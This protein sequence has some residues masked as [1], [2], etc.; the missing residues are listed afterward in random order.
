MAETRS[1]D[2]LALVYNYLPKE[3]LDVLLDELL[4]GSG[5]EK[6]AWARVRNDSRYEMWYPGNLTEDGRPR[7][8]ESRYAFTVEQYRD[9]YR[10]YKLNVDILNPRI[11][12]LVRGEVSPTEFGDRVQVTWERVVSASESTQQYYTTM[13]GVPLT[14]EA[15]LAGALDPTLG[16]QILKDEISVAEVG[17]QALGSGFDM[18]ISRVEELVSEGMDVERADKLFGDAE[19]LVPILN[20]LAQ[21]HNDPDDDYDVEEFL[22]ADFFRDP[23]ENL[24]MRRMLSQERS[25][26]KNNLTARRS[27]TGGLTGLLAE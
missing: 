19:R 12:D 6:V 22:Q 14:V 21:R 10:A 24:R 15:M 25:L 16:T 4:D 17:G 2:E 26:F 18:S 27:E 13:K 8:D 7:Y 3:A 11:G 9:V 1:R 5:D 20:V 23:E